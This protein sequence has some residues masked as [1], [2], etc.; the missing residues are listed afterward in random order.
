MF[1]RDREEGVSAGEINI[2]GGGPLIS[3]LSKMFSN[4][5]MIGI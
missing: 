2:E 5:S 1:E 3:P 4:V